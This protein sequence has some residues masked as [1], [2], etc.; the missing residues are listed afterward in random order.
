MEL[1]G[2]KIK[3]LDDGFVLGVE[4]SET[5]NRFLDTMNIEADPDSLSLLMRPRKM[6]LMA[7]IGYKPLPV[8]QVQNIYL[9]HSLKAKSSMVLTYLGV[10]T[11]DPVHQTDVWSLLMIVLSEAYQKAVEVK[12]VAPSKSTESKSKPQKRGGSGT[13]STFRIGD[14]IPNSGEPIPKSEHDSKVS[15]ILFGFYKQCK[16]EGF[17]ANQGEYSQGPGREHLLEKIKEAFAEVAPSESQHRH[18]VFGLDLR[19]KIECLCN[20]M[21]D[22]DGSDHAQQSLR[23]E[24]V[25]MLVDARQGLIR[26]FEYRDSELEG[27][28]IRIEDYVALGFS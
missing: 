12:L 27:T 5:A 26:E 8:L 15:K 25:M 28:E 14:E 18:L 2:A 7:K 20:K 19:S 13:G 24:I 6:D 10:A 21:E 22:I 3:K 17:R 9:L 16:A 1:K 4:F 23:Q 11:S